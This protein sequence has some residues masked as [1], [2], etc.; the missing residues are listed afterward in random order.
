[1]KDLRPIS[2]LKRFGV[3]LSTFAMSNILRGLRASRTM[4]VVLAH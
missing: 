4:R 1:V 2:E 3:A